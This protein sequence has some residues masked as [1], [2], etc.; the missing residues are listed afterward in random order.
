MNYSLDS[1]SKEYL[2]E[3]KKGYDL[4][5][6]VLNI[7]TETGTSIFTWADFQKKVPI[8]EREDKIDP[9]QFKYKDQ[10]IKVET[11]VNSW[12]LENHS[13]DIKT[14][15]KSEAL[16]ASEVLT[17]ADMRLE[18]GESVLCHSGARIERPDRFVLHFCKN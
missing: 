1:L 15:A 14:M 18:L 9:D 8:E 4:R 13:L 16:T 17:A 12:I 7:I 5:E 3:S 10:I 6:K 11:L 2:K